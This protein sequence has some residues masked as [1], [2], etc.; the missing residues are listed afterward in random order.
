[1]RALSAKRWNS[2]KRYVPVQVGLH[3]VGVLTEGNEQHAKNWLACSSGDFLSVA[4]MY[5]KH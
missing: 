1:M 4:S 2:G 3:V 5:R